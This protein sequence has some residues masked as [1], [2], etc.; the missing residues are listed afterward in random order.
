[1]LV[2]AFDA[3]CCDLSPDNVI[4]ERRVGQDDRQK[5]EYEL[6]GVEQHEGL[7]AELR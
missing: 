1:M 6:R 7:F 4:D 2:R 5:H 3:G